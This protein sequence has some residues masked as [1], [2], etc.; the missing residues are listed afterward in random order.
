MR[1]NE[2]RAFASKALTELAARLRPAVNASAGA[3]Q[4]LRTARRIGDD[5]HQNA[6]YDDAEKYMN[7]SW[8]RLIWPLIQDCDFSAVVDLAA[9]HGRNTEKLRQ[10]AAKVWVADIN[11][12]NID[13]CR[14]RFRGDARVAY[15]PCDGVSLTGIPDGAVSLLYCFDAMVHFDSDTVRAYLRDF[16][17]ALRPGGRGF[18][19]HSNYTLAPVGDHRRNPHWRNFMSKELFE[20]YCDK[21]GLRVVRQQVIDWDEA[22]SLDCMT[23]FEKTRA[24]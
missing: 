11:A 13:F 18:C 3:D 15:A 10:I 9:G 24:S 5:W 1:T 16:H 12:E 14:A 17:R 6:Y 4:A 2:L 21:E 20:H 19:H 7:D 23:V 8:T 22:K